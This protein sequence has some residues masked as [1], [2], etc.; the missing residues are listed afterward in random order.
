MTTEAASGEN[1]TESASETE[2]DTAEQLPISNWSKKSRSAKKKLEELLRRE[3]IEAYYCIAP[4]SAKNNV[5]IL[6]QENSDE[7]VLDENVSNIDD[8]SQREDHP[9][10]SRLFVLGAFYQN[11]QYDYEGQTNEGLQESK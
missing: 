4:A 2:T 8:L 1:D 7:V 9:E 3:G 5:E 11:L 10:L 6:N